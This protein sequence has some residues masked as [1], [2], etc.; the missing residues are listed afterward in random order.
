MRI[1]QITLGAGAT[2]LAV[3]THMPNNTYFSFLIIQNN[4][5]TAAF[6]IGDNTVSAT[7][8][9]SVGVSGSLTS[10]IFAPHGGCL[11]QW[12][13]FGTAGQVVDFLY[14]TSQ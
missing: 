8:G 1:G 11:Q 4:G 3:F 6:R 10:Q 13:A 12:Y 2:P 14:E 7:R 5:T 9:I